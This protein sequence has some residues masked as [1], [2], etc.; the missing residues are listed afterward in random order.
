MQQLAERRVS[1]NGT[2]VT[3][4][5][6]E[7]NVFTQVEV[8]SVVLQQARPA[9]YLMLHKPPG[10]ASATKDL[11]HPTVLDLITEPWKDELHIAGRLDF[12]TSG[13]MLLTN[14]GRWSRRITEPAEQ[15][16]KVY[17]VDTEDPIHP[18]AIDVF[19]QGIYFRFEDLTTRPAALEIITPTRARL[20]LHEGR[21]HQVKRMFGVFNNK[22]IGLHRESMGAIRLDETLQAGQYRPL[23]TR[24]VASV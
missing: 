1:V 23:T 24:E 10:C 20:T 12:N 5:L 11:H 13:L 14:D 18:D 2:I 7:I 15:K 6:H 16:A 3:D 21:Y 9:Y 19:A 4:G 22:V 8:D 17:L